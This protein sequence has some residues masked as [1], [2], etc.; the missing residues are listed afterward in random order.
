MSAGSPVDEDLI[1]DEV[2]GL[3]RQGMTYMC[4]AG[5]CSY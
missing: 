4:V 1:S 2:D 3:K 5:A